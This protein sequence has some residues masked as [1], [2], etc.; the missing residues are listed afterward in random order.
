MRIAH[1]IA[2]VGLLA[3]AAWMLPRS[4]TPD[5]S[6]PAPMPALPTP[7]AAAIVA[8]LPAGPTAVL[9]PTLSEQV[10]RLIASHDPKD[11][12]AAY[13]LLADCATFNR[14]GDRL[15][16]GTRNRDG[17]LPGFRNL[18]A[19]E[20]ARDARLCPG[21]TERMR[22]SRIDY[23]AI[24]A[25]AGVDGA[26][27]KMAG[28]GPFG[29][30]GALLV[31]PDDPLVREWKNEV[32]ALLERAADDGDLDVLEYIA[33]QYAN[34]NALFDKH[35]ALAY[36]YG[37]ATGLI[38]RDLLAAGDTL[39]ALYAPDGAMMSGVGAAL[40]AEQRAQELAAAMR[41]AELAR[42]RRQQARTQ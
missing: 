16:F 42:A 22:L 37:V 9:A 28:E 8:P 12:M 5:A 27:I 3:A 23:L 31:R 20:K 11:A 32:V 21:M 1:Y 4:T 40:N 30:P 25:R 13:Q 19:A 14:D 36:R 29:D 35:P 17:T 2:A 33:F 24:A 39:A 26:A 7:P 41:I 34:G 10:D 6:P 15:V 38:Y 18:N